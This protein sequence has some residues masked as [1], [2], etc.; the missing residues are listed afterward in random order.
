MSGQEYIKIGNALNLSNVFK[1]S[2]HLTKTLNLI[3]VL[4]KYKV[5]GVD[6]PLLRGDLIFVLVRNQNHLK[7]IWVPSLISKGVPPI[8]T[9][10][11]SLDSLVLC[12]LSLG[13]STKFLDFVL[14]LF[15]IL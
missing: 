5:L 11:L 13:E 8:F 7:I 10:I 3:G 4:F 9:F 6:D 14:M 2:S 15:Y 12:C 1:Q